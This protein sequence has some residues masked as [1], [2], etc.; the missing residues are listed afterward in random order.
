MPTTTAWP[1]ILAA[2]EKIRWRVEDL[3][4]PD[5]SYDF[6]KPFMP[7]SLARTKPLAFLSKDEQLALN[8]IRGHGYLHMFGLVEEFILPF[9]VDHGREHLSGDDDFRTRSLLTFADEEAKHIQLFKRF[10]AE[11][12]RRFGQECAAIGPAADVAKAILAH[13]DLGVALTILLIEWMS[14]R[15]WIEAIRSD[16][17]LDDRF[18]SLLQHHWMEEAQHAHMDGLIV[19]ELAAGRDAAQRSKALD[20]F[21]AIGGFVDEGLKQQTQFDLEALERRIGRRLTDAQREQF[22]AVQHQAMRW[23]FLGSGMTH[24]KFLEALDRLGPGLR[25]RV[26]QAAP[27]FS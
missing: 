15:H 7:E 22:L 8:H 17:A 20:E 4:G 27:I 18:K 16:A 24:P 9:V 11:F 1:E 3:I 13:D 25:A 10:K 5:K 6:T 2:T 26:E 14:Q 19:E 23:T 21:F 12:A